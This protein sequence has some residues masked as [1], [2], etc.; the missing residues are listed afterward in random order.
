MQ[1]VKQNKTHFIINTVLLYKN[2]MSV[3]VSQTRNIFLIPQEH[4]KL[5]LLFQTYPCKWFF[6]KCI[7]VLCFKPKNTKSLS[8]EPNF[9]VQIWFQL[10][11]HAAEIQRNLTIKKSW[12]YWST[13][14]VKICVLYSVFTICWRERKTSLL[15]FFKN[16]Q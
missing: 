3:M 1:I 2:K 12:K 8:A 7:C 4:I 13:G 9:V 16:L 10:Q 15:S 14:K 6:F 5:Y 11:C